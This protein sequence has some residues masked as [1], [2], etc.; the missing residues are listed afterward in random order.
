MTE[1]GRLPFDA[2]NAALKAAGED[3]RLRVLV[4]LSEAELTVS[5]LMVPQTINL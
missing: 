5:D 3:T 1:T 4:L 2:L